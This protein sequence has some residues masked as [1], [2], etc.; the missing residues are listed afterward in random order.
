MSAKIQH[1]IVILPRVVA[2]IAIQITDVGAIWRHREGLREAVLRV[3]EEC[4]EARAGWVPSLAEEVKTTRRGVSIRIS[5]SGH[6][7]QAYD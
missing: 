7:L 1:M 6:P 3:L 5:D 4:N 2:W